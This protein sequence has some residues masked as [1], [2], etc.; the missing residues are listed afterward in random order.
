MLALNLIKYKV[1][2]CL[3]NQLIGQVFI[4]KNLYGILS[5]SSLVC[6]L[7][8]CRC[9]GMNMKEL[10]ISDVSEQKEKI[11]AEYELLVK[12]PTAENMHAYQALVKD[13]VSAAVAQLYM[14]GIK[15]S[16]ENMPQ[17]NLY[18]KVSEMDAVLQEIGE[19]VDKGD[20]ESLIERCGRLNALLDNL[21]WYN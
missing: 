16:W 13:F 2:Y 11:A 21:L 7:C 3:G 19:A 8:F 6:F 10:L 4:N 1:L 9:R 18:G 15:S 20:K 14:A 17:Q 5:A 12:N